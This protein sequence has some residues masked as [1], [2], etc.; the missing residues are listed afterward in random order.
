MRLRER[1]VQL[2]PI[3]V[4]A[5][6]ILPATAS[7]SAAYANK[8]CAYRQQQAH[9]SVPSGRE[10]Q[11]ASRLCGQRSPLS[12]NFNVCVRIP[13]AWQP[14]ARGSVTGESSAVIPECGEVP[15]AGQFGFSAPIVL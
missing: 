1:L 7:P 14:S 12:I 8:I 15:V 13:Q 11:N 6:E 4:R 9:R 5:R 2:P 3:P 10:N